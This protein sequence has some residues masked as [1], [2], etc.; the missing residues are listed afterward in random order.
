MKA[1]PGHDLCIQK[2]CA[3]PPPP[4]PHPPPPTCC[5]NCSESSSGVFSPKLMP[6]P[7]VCGSSLDACSLCTGYLAK[8]K[9]PHPSVRFQ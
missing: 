5:W 6:L 7:V 9:Q 3:A 2:A 4:N 1:V 8:R